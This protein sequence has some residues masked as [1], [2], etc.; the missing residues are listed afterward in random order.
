MSTGVRGKKSIA[1]TS[2]TLVAGDYDM[3][4]SSLTPSVSLQIDI[5]GSADDSFVRG[6]VSVTVNDC[7]SS[8]HSFQ[9]CCFNIQTNCGQR[10]SQCFVKVF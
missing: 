7:V 4:K 5:P 9:T 6:Q 1:P 10:A 8:I 2:T 3:T